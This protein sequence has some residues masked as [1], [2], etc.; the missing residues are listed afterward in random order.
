MS[1]I[2]A[3]RHD[4]NAYRLMDG[5]AIVG[6]ALR[7]A[8]GSWGLYD[9]DE[10]RLAE[11]TF[12]TPKAAAAAWRDVVAPK[13]AASETATAIDREALGAIVRRAWAEAQ[14]AGLSSREADRRAGE[15]VARN[16]L[17]A[18]SASA[19]RAPADPAVLALLAV[20]FEIDRTGND[21]HALPDLLVGLRAALAP[22]RV[23][24][25]AP[26]APDPRDPD[27]ARSERTD[28]GYA[29]EVPVDGFIAIERAERF[30]GM[31]GVSLGE[32]LLRVPGVSDVEYNGHFGNLIHFRLV[33]EHD[34]PETHRAVLAV[35]DD[36]VAACK[37]APPASARTP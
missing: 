20:A 27:V 3:R 6:F 14:D 5:G 25:K 34:R 13:V 30:G 9:G 29:V 21:A 8:D 19:G 11:R 33:A 35:I 23:A 18:L 32:R 7:L 31:E 10:R 2:L 28:A 22:F 37:A 17:A 1:G 15:A 24:A 12:P 36:H 4:A 16:A 26:D